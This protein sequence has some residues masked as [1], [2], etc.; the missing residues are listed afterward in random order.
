MVE[1]GSCLPPV[2]PLVYP[3]SIPQ[4]NSQSNPKFTLWA[5]FSLLPSLPLVYSQSAS[6]LSPSLHPSMLPVYPQSTSQSASQSASS[7]LPVCPLQPSPVPV[8]AV[9]SIWNVFYPPFPLPILQAHCKELILGPFSSPLAT[10]SY[11][12]FLR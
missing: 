11:R 2:N 7:L 4:V 3:Y 5:A 6:S 8:L 10:P 1:A 12:A 9:L